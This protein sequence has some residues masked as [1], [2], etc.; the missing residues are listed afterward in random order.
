MMTEQQ[1]M[2]HRSLQ[3]YAKIVQLNKFNK[4]FKLCLK[5]Y[6]L[7]RLDV[8]LL[9]LTKCKKGNK[10]KKYVN[11]ASFFISNLVDLPNNT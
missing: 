9:H 4:V 2:N 1:H 3:L 8:Y 5:P 7:K 11:E 6:L 10:L